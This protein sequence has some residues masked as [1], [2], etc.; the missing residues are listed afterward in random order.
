MKVNIRNLYPPVVSF[1]IFFLVWEIAVKLSGVPSFILPSLSSVLSAIFA[2]LPWLLYNSYVTLHESVLGFLGGSLVG[3]LLG[4]ALSHSKTLMRYTYPLIVSGQLLPKGAVAPLFL[5][6]FGYGIL[7]KIAIAALISFF[8]LVINSMV[9]FRLIKSEALDL[10]HSLR[11]SASQIFF[12]A[13]L[14]N[15]L[16]YI[17]GGLKVAVTLSMVGAIVG[18]FV[19]ANEGLG[20]LIIVA[21]SQMNSPLMFSCLMLVSLSGLLFYGAVCGIERLAIPWAEHIEAQ[22]AR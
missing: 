11:A 20:Y 1:L 12:R 4:I 10:M 5:I 2:G 14:P 13:S 19:G 16:P 7:P 8:P 17:F 3:I 9:G 18:E 15:A 6:W 22:S 21:A